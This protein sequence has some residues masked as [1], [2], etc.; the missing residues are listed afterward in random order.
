M[1]T[2]GEINLRLLSSKDLILLKQDIILEYEDRLAENQVHHACRDEAKLCNYL[3]D[4]QRE[5]QAIQKDIS[6][7]RFWLAECAREMT[8]RDLLSRTRHALQKQGTA[9]VVILEDHW[10]QRRSREKAVG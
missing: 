3:E 1:H 2:H 8:R 7:L 4:W 5:N 9:N 6:E 10:L